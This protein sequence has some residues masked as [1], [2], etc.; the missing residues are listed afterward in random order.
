MKRIL[1][2]LT[3]LTVSM[4]VFAD[5]SI[6]ADLKEF[7]RLGQFDPKIPFSERIQIM[8][9]IKN[10]VTPLISQ[11]FA[12]LVDSEVT[13]LMRDLLNNPDVA[14]FAQDVLGDQ[15]PTYPVDIQVSVLKK[16]FEA[17]PDSLRG[18]LVLSF[19]DDLP[20]E[21]FVGNEIQGWLVKKING[22]VPAGA[23]YFILT[24]ES[25][26]AVSKTA[27]ANMKRFSKRREDN[28]SNLF[29]LLSAVFLAS[30]GDADA[31]KLLDSLLDQRNLDSLLD[32]AYVLQA[33][34]MSE[35]E[36]L[37]LKVRDIIVTDK[38]SRSNGDS[39]PPETS[40]AQIA[41]S[42]CSLTLE[43]F[44][45]VDYWGDY[46]DEMKKK[47]HDWLKDNPTHTIK[48]DFIR[49]FFQNTPF[50]SIIPAMWQNHWGE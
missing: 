27:T 38:R 9:K 28:E 17:T 18:A 32:T 23:F 45:S 16:V 33:A 35:N 39:N 26:K 14:F 6:I 34:A 30:R 7:N 21:A 40:F 15:L 29:S 41:A 44:P 36:K 8:D 3:Q 24:D 12:K 20:K 13:P 1:F 42:V 2:L 22:G 46:D 11:E 37:I 43:G 19:W 49:G 50:Q 31:F 48:P 5:L 47:V 4:N 10:R 25:A